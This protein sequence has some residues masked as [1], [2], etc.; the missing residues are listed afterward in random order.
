MNTTVIAIKPLLY[1]LVTEEPM[2]S[3]QEINRKPML[4]DM[5][6]CNVNMDELSTEKNNTYYFPIFKMAPCR[7]RCRVFLYFEVFQEKGKSAWTKI[8]LHDIHIV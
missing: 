1:I 2:M 6:I 8:S 5:A 4:T 3:I 7:S